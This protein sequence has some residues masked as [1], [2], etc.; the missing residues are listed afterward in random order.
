LGVI[1]VLI[2]ILF[3]F[4]C[5]TLQITKGNIAYDLLCYHYEQVN[6]SGVMP[7]IFSTS[8]LALPGTLA[9]FTGLEFLK[10]AAISLNPGGALYIP[11]NVLL[12]AFFNYYYT[13]LQ[14]DPD[15]LSEQLKRQGASIPLVRPG[16][17]TAAFIKTVSYC[18]SIRINI[19]LSPHPNF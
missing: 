3:D 16:K 8:S 14:L 15:D 10:K 4:L 18:S 1:I 7:I 13:F 5:P 2:S 6:S 12:I 11:T 9:R 19:V 17:S